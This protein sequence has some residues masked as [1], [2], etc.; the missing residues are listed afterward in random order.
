MKRKADYQ[1]HMLR[2]ECWIDSVLEREIVTKRSR[3]RKKADLKGRNLK[4]NA[5]DLNLQA[6]AW[7]LCL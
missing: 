1:D 2:R 7:Q 4:V 5:P 3:G 6:T